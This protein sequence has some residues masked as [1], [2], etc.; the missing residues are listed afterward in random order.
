MAWLQRNTL[1]RHGEAGAWSRTGVVVIAAG[2][3]G[4]AWL[5]SVI[6][7]GDEAMVAT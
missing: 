4:E 7:V 3:D 2:V 1:S 6:V 5:A